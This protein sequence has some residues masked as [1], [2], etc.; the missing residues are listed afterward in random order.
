MTGVLSP[1]L[2]ACLEKLR[3]SSSETGFEP[4]SATS[5]AFW[6]VAPSARGSV[7]GTPSSMMS[8]P[9]SC[10]ASSVSTVCS[11]EG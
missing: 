6:I 2:T 4:A 5:F 11:R 10:I 3:Q 9:P 1:L 8:V 7:N